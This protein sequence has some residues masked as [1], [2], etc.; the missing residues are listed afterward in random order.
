[1]PIESFFVNI[2]NTGS[3]M[4]VL[5]QATHS[6]FALLLGEELGVSRCVWHEEETDDPKDCRYDAL[7]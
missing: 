2:S 5:F 6:N 3:A 7:D 4:C 1:M